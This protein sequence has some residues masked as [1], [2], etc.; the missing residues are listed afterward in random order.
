MQ[1]E[2]HAILTCYDDRLNPTIEAFIKKIESEG[3]IVLSPVRPIGGVH[4]MT[5]G[6]C[7]SFFYGQ[8]DGFIEIGGARHIHIFPHTTCQFNVLK[9]WE[10]IGETPGGD[11]QFQVS[12]LRKVLENS[13][14]HVASKYS[15]RKIAL[16]V[17]IIHTLEQRI[18]TLEE[19][20][21]LLLRHQAHDSGCDRTPLELR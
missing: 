9:Q 10:K 19:A 14:S 17:R 18:I 15:D 21:D 12:T 11:I 7:R 6:H 16:D 3:G 13:E 4:A 2:R 20:L 5:Q 8:L 1:Q